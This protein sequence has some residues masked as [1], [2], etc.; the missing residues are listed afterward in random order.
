DGGHVDANDQCN[1]PGTPGDPTDDYITFE[2]NPTGYNL[3][4]DYTVTVPAGYTVSP[5]TGNYGV[6]TAFTLNNGSAGGGAVAIIITDNQAGGDTANVTITDSNTCSGESNLTSTGLANT[7]CDNNSTPGDP[8]DD[9]I[10]FDLS[11]QGFN[12]GLD[13]SVI[14]PS[15]YSVT[16]STANYGISSSFELGAMSAGGGDVFVQIVDNQ[17]GGDT[18]SFTLADPGTCSNESNIIDNGLANVNCENN[19]TPGNPTDDYISFDLTPI[20]YNLGTEY[21]VT[22]PMGYTVTPSV[23]V[24]GTNTTF[25]FSLQNGSAGNGQVLITIHDNQNNGD[26]FSFMM[27]DPG[28]CSEESNITNT[29]LQNVACNNNGTPEWIYDDYISF[30]LNPE[31][32]NLSADYSIV[33]PEGYSI[34]PMGG[35]Y[36]DTTYFELM[37]GSAGGGDVV[38]QLVDNQEDGD[39]VDVLIVDPN[40]CS[41][42]PD[43]VITDTVIVNLDTVTYCVDTTILPGNITNIEDVCLTENG[44]YVEFS[45]DT[46][47]LCVTYLGVEFSGTDTMCLQLTDSLGHVDTIEFN[48]TCISPPSGECVSDSIFI[49]QTLYYCVDTN[50][51]AGN[52]VRFEN[53]CEDSTFVKYDLIDSNFCVSYTGRALGDGSACIVITDEYGI[54]DTTYF[55]TEVVPY[56]GLPEAIDDEFCVLMNSSKVYDILD[57]DGT[58]GGVDSLYILNPPQYGQIEINPDLTITYTPSQN[59]CER[60]DEVLY[61]FCNPNG[62]SSAIIHI[63][64]ECEDIVIFTAV[65]PNSDGVNDEFYISNIE[66]YTNNELTIF[67]R[68]GNVVHHTHSYRNHWGGKWRDKYLPD[69][70]YYYLLQLNDEEN[71]V[72]SGYL[73]ISR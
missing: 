49:N 30:E 59:I 8:T 25:H 11:P 32:F 48:I 34:N 55:C 45:I 43:I 42:K 53:I 4:A 22:V 3:A 58:W 35:M 68:W 71:R 54:T 57:N 38:L 6:A 63:C 23:G 5:A 62:C 36:G 56:T 2:L 46:A 41:V 70:T 73:Q 44:E 17:V 29:N 16:P 14:V 52:I 64:I 28:T 10:L 61:E 27:M 39:T 24:F 21:T 66:K 67:N 12:L 18:I 7:A 72:F 47:N 15:G 37:N 13:Y 9:K 20:G 50:Q 65:S 33:L 1:D 51:L 31:G 26:D 19:L 69:G 60:D 40:I